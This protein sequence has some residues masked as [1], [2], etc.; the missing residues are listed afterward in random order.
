M[1][2]AAA[3]QERAESIR[4]IRDSVAAIATRGDLKRIRALRF[5]EAGFDP[6]AWKAMGDLGWI[7]LR[8][9]E[10]HGGAGL[11]MAECCALAEELGRCLVPEPLVEGMLSATLLAAAGE[12]ALL[13]R[14]LAGDAVV[15]T[16]WQEAADT[17]VSPGGAAV[18]RVFIPMARAATHFLVPRAEPG[19]LSLWLVEGPVAETR[20]MQDGGHVGFLDPGGAAG[21]RLSGDVGAALSRALDEAALTTAAYL[22]GVMEQAFAM[23]LDYLRTRSQFGRPIGSFQALQH[24]AVDLRI[25]AALTRASVEDAAATLD[26]LDD[27][28]IAP[29]QAAGKPSAYPSAS[30]RHSAPAS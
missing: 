12:E 15:L 27:R 14:L 9:T 6:V 28:Q 11:G 1:D 7:G 2:N 30:R 13:A 25:Q 21:R 10:D 8:L 4:M 5:T 22:L 19:G 23:T 24:R 29:R 20:P 17:L 16:A 3:A 18:R 26:G